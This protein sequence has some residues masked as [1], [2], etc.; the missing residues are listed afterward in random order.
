MNA[1]SEVYE[2]IVSLIYS[3]NAD[4]IPNYRKYRNIPESNCLSNDLISLKKPFNYI[5]TE[6]FKSY[7]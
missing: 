5:F 4:A 3:I 7:R 2:N 6:W 1:C